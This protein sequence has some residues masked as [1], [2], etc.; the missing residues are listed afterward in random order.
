MW[1]GPSPHVL[2]LQAADDEAK[3]RGKGGGFDA[4]KNNRASTSVEKVLLADAAGRAAADAEAAKGVL[5]WHYY[6]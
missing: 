1:Y 4:E 6:H 2:S 5:A 3:G